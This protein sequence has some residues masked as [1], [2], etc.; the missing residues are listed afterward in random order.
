MPRLVSAVTYNISISIR[1]VVCGC[2]FRCV[3]VYFM[4]ISS[5]VLFPYILIS[6]RIGMAKLSKNSLSELSSTS[7]LHQEIAVRILSIV[8]KDIQPASAS[9]KP[10][11]QAAF[12]VVDGDGNWGNI[13]ENIWGDQVARRMIATQRKEQFLGK[14]F[15]LKGMS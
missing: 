3:A 14:C 4:F 12:L 15:L 11:A 13:L 8:I 6:I 5:S 10:W 2:A 1:A 9:K 7:G